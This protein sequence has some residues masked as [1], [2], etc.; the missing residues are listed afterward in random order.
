[1]GPGA[2]ILRSLVLAVA[3]LVL[4]RL[5]GKR[6]VGEVSAIDLVAGVTIGTIAGATSITRT[7][8]LWGGLL[9]LAVWGAFEWVSA[10]L[11]ARLP[12]LEKLLS[13]R[14][15]TLVRAGSVSRRGLRKAMLSESAL[16]SMLRVRH[17]A[18]LAE[19]EEASL[20]PSGKLGVIPRRQ[21]Q[22]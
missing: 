1:M 7:I 14:S 3:L 17:A 4:V 13:G 16:R 15:T 2:F 18:D 22:S 11:S 9:A 20:E 6:L 8:P 21:P 5:I 10:S 12:T 19:V